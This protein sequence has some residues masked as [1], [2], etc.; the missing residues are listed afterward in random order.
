MSAQAAT[1]LREYADSPLHYE[2][3]D[4]SATNLQRRVEMLTSVSSQADEDF[5]SYH[6]GIRAAQASITQQEVLSSHTFSAVPLHIQRQVLHT[7]AGTCV[8]YNHGGLVTSRH[9][10]IRT[11]T[12]L[13]SNPN[14]SPHCVAQW[15]DLCT[16]THGL[17]DAVQRVPST[18]SHH[19]F[20]V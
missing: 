6:P 8:W 17:H 14:H 15:A 7:I 18:L 16:M 2:H 11:H 10:Q 3:S 13:A 20:W 12:Q 19:W 9:H 1:L 5:L 4:D